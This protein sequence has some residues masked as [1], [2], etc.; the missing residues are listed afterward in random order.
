MIPLRNYHKRS[1]RKDEGSERE[2]KN[3]KIQYKKYHGVKLKY[4]FKTK[5]KRDREKMIIYGR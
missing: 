3:E 4:L 1:K 5:K 2:N